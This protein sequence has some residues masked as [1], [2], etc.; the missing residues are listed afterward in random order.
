METLSSENLEHGFGTHVYNRAPLSVTLVG[1]LVEVLPVGEFM[2]EREKTF[3]WDCT[4][5][6]H[7]GWRRSAGGSIRKAGE[8]ESSWGGQCWVLQEKGLGAGC[9]Q[10]W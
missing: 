10:S 8:L 2:G 9:F 3:R 7:G 5:F 6:T 4:T 1:L